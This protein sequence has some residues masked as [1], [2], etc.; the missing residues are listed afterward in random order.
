M[1]ERDRHAPTSF[2]TQIAV[3]CTVF[4]VAKASKLECQP[5]EKRRK[6]GPFCGFFHTDR[7]GKNNV[8][9]QLVPLNL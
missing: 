3:H 2:F 7:A 1:M 5:V 4:M 8:N 6:F 9:I